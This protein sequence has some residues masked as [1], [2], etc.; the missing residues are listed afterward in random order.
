MEGL[1]EL[2]RAEQNLQIKIQEAKAEFES[3]IYKKQADSIR[4][5]GTTQANE[6]ISK[7]LTPEYIKWKWVERLNDGT[8]EVIYVPTEANLPILESTKK[9]Q[10]ADK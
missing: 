3:V 5:I 8:G 1:A 9:L 10:K 6:I 7:S 2:R 4:A